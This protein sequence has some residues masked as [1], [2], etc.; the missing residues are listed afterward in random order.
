MAVEAVLYEEIEF[1]RRIEIGN[2][3]IFLARVFFPMPAEVVG[4]VIEAPD[5]GGAG[6]EADFLDV[7][8]A[9]DE[10]F[11]V[12]R[13]LAVEI[14]D[15]D[16]LAVGVEV[17]GHVGGIGAGDEEL[18]VGDH[19]SFKRMPA[20]R[21]DGVLRQDVLHLIGDAVALGVL[22]P[23][24]RALGRLA[25]VEPAV[26]HLHALYGGFVLDE[27][28]DGLEDAVAVG[29]TEGEDGAGVHLREK[30]RL[31]VGGELDELRPPV[32]DPT[33][34]GVGVGVVL[35]GRVIGRLGDAIPGPDAERGNAR[36]EI[37][38]RVVGE[39]GEGDSPKASITSEKVSSFMGGKLTP[40]V[41]IWQMLW[42]HQERKSN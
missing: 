31:A 18:L 26:A 13:G 10:D 22:C 38:R 16:F 7:A 33:P 15:V 21:G 14:P 30:E 42:H 3:L 40:F 29:I 8:D 2:G 11:F 6:A 24:D 1:L 20:A 23:P 12:G 39:L 28:S 9:G 35:D 27:D 41:G 19:D 32:T 5:V 4:A 36:A 34:A 17:V 25:E 37:R